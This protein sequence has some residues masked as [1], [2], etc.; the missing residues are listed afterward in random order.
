MLIVLIEV[1]NWS[2]EFV[3]LSHFA[4]SGVFGQE[5]IYGLVQEKR[6]SIANALGLRFSCTDPSKYLD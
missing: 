2:M 1:L 3:F 5:Y 4:I 6:S